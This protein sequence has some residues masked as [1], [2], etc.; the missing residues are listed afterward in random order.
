MTLE[1]ARYSLTRL[2]RRHRLVMIIDATLWGVAAAGIVY[3][4]A[5]LF[6]LSNTIAFL[7]AIPF[8]VAAF[9][10]R[11]RTLG[12]YS[13]D[14]QEMIR[15]INA[16]YKQYEESTDLLFAQRELTTLQL[17]Q[18]SRTLSVYTQSHSEIYISNRL[19][20]AIGASLIAVIA[21]ALTYYFLPAP[22]QQQQRPTE[23]QVQTVVEPK[24]PSAIRS[25]ELT[26]T[27]PAYT[28]LSKLKSQK[29]STAVPEASS[30][31]WI[32]TFSDKV[33]VATLRIGSADSLPMKALGGNRFSIQ[34]KPAESFIYQFTWND[35]TDK[36]STSPYYT[37]EITRDQAPLIKVEELNQF[38]QLT[39]KDEPVI[40]LKA[41]LADDFG[42]NSAHIIAT[43]SKGSG[44]SVKFREEKLQFTSPDKIAGKQL[45]ATRKIDLKKLGMEPGDELY[46]YVEAFDNKVPS[47]NRTR[48]ETFF[49]SLQDTASQELSLDAGLGVDL[50]PEY[51]R[52]QRQIIIDTEKLLRDRKKL[53]AHQFKQT[54]NEL[55]Y[56]QKV[57]R[58][59]Y[60]EFL[61]EEFESGIGPQNPTTGEGA[62]SIEEAVKQYGHA[63]DTENEH[64][65]VE[66]KKS[67]QKESPKEEH[68]HHEGEEGEEESPLEA[69]AHNHDNAEEATFFVLSVKAKLKAALTVMWD[70]EL[71]LRV[72]DPEK[73]LPYQYQA[74]KLLKEISQDS[75]VYVH[76]TGFD[77]PPIKEESRLKGDLNETKSTS[78]F[79]KSNPTEQFPA[80]A[81]ALS[82][83]EKMITKHQTTIS[84]TARVTLQQAGNEISGIAL[85]KPGEYLKTLSLIQDLLQGN[86]PQ[87]KITVSLMTLRSTFWTVVPQK[88]PTPDSK[89]LLLHELDREFI[90]NLPH[91]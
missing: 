50:M 83:V 67:S 54:S 3:I 78:D 25:V 90:E 40:N 63:H 45:R 74:L 39:Q 28:S 89:T 12:L 77:P 72:Y 27:P 46:F 36:Q 56:D 24:L 82:L 69:F 2:T 11:S 26:V 33:T 7:S 81:R 53:T 66:D 79:Y 44:E 22:Q 52:S 87:E 5:S 55:G 37:I 4:V 65:L 1:E 29:L 10:F 13:F 14:E 9:A 57:L 86:V 35:V 80:T 91:D 64:N 41:N 16:N 47:P 62:Q 58:L 38:T 59:K 75:R 8:G 70:A 71:Y 34:R 76:R 88:T 19:P 17:I 68:H 42:L 84:P 30:V 23:K 6:S 43:V 73:S 31:E 18:Q 85:Q 21:A 20:V 15:L 61:G 60:G 51:F 48:T 49:I 32:V